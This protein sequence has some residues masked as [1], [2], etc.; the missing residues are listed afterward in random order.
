MKSRPI[1]LVCALLLVGL[2]LTLATGCATSSAAR[3]KPAKERIAKKE[4]DARGVK[5]KNFTLHKPSDVDWK[6]IRRGRKAMGG[7]ALDSY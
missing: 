4:R 6:F 5:P 3:T 7:P 1:A 2:E